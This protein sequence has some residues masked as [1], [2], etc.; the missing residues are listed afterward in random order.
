MLAPTY[1]V[2]GEND[3]LTVRMYTDALAELPAEV[4]T[5]KKLELIAGATGL[6]ETPYLLQ[7]V[8]GLASQWFTRHLEPIV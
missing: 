4:E 5:N 7:K 1:L 6:F 8:T 2:A 3:T